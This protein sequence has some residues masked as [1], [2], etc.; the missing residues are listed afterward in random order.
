MSRYADFIP[1]N[2]APKT[3]RRIG[4]YDSNG[5]RAGT[6][7]LGSLTF[8]SNPGEKL[9]SFG[10]LSDIHL[11]PNVTAQDDFRRALTYL[12]DVE[13]VAFT[14]IA[15][16]LTDAGTA[17]ELSE[18][19][20]IVDTY[21]PNMT[22]YAITGN[23]DARNPNIA[24]DFKTHTGC[25]LYYSFEYEGDVFIMV[26]IKGV[27]ESGKWP[28]SGSLFSDVELQWLSET[29]ETNKDKRCFLFQHV[30][31]QEGSGNALGQYHLDIWGGAEQT[32]FESLLKQYPNAVF[33]HG[34]SHLKFQL[35]AYD[36]LA[37][38]DHLRGSHSV[39]IPSLAIP[40]EDIDG[41]GEGDK[42]ED[43][44][45]GYVVDVYENGIHLR[46]RDFVKGEFLPIASYWVDTN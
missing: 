21:S 37:N 41:D 3:V 33:F 43:G 14:C 10:A 35:Q 46:G 26:G 5:N 18:Y 11:Q 1:E 23:H 27:S 44:S 28:D 36:D 31:P 12:N 6:I 15:G 24:V 45:E 19:R 9:Y 40:R 4:V 29:L 32:V 34:H 2:I 7:P 17:A 30:R 13:K 8:P 25:D 39:H 16:D 42:I 22:I 20:Q 38:Y